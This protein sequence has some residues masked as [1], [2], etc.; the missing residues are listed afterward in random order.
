[1]TAFIVCMR[2]SASSK[3]MDCGPSK[4]SFVTSSASRPYF[5]PT[6]LPMVVFRSWKAGSQSMNTAVGLA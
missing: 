4:T 5:S 1:M 2:F 6:S 3:T